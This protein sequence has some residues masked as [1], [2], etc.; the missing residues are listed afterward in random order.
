MNDFFTQYFLYILAFGI[1][2]IAQS[3]VQAAYHKYKQIP[4]EKGIKGEDVA[5]RIL[6]ANGLM[7]VRVEVA[8]GGTLSDHYDPVHNVIRLSPDIF[9]N[10]SI[11]SI[12]VA[13]HEVGHAIQHK[14]HYGAISIRNRLLPMANI[15]SKLGW[16]VLVLGLFLF[17]S[18]PMIVYLGI[19]L[20]GIVLLFQVVTLPVEFNASSRA[21]KQ[22]TQLQ[23]INSDETYLAKGML[24][25][26]AFTY[27]AAVLSTVTQILRILLMVLGR[28]NDD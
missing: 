22:L 10:A 5:R 6:D 16:V 2:M 3:R 7:N 11:A 24:N 15:A 19:A 21:I 8:N 9:Y 26:A 20:I 27:V 12:S 14:E 23:F 1:V 28:N 13:A 25:A 17:A 4:N 18:T